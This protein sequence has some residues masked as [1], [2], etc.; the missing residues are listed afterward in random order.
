MVFIDFPFPKVSSLEHSKPSMP[1]IDLIRNLYRRPGQHG[2]AAC[3]RCAGTQ[4]GSAGN[5]TGQCL[6]AHA[7]GICMSDFLKSE[8]CHQP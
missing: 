5:D 4:Q 6:R 3:H 1:S 8:F 7:D 2:G